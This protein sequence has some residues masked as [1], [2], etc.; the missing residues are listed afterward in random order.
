[1]GKWFWPN[2]NLLVK[3]GRLVLFGSASFTPTGNLHPILNIFNI[4]DV[5]NI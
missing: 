2:Y 3:E 1:M 5:C 4:L